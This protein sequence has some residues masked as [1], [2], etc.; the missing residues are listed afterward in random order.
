M[1]GMDVFHLN[2]QWATEQYG[3]MTFF[4]HLKNSVLLGCDNDN[5]FY[6]LFG[7]A[8]DCAILTPSREGFQSMLDICAKYL[9]LM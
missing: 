5:Y 7:Y 9:A 1:G 4:L 8:D 2:F 3:A 6:G